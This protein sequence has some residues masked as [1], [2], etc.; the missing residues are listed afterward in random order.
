MYCLTAQFEFFQAV[1]QEDVALFV[2]L[3]GMEKSLDFEINDKGANLLHL[4]V[5]RGRYVFSF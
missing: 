3:G 2:D 5:F 1:Y 4:A